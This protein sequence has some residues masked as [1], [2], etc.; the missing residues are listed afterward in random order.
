MSSTGHKTKT[1]ERDYRVKPDSGLAGAWKIAIG[2]GV[3]GLVAAGFGYT[4]DPTRFAF[5]YL[6]AFFLFL[7]IGLGGLFFVLI[8]YLTKAG[9]SVTVRRTAEFFMGGLWVFVILVIPIALMMG[10]LFPWLEDGQA[11]QQT[12][13]TAAEAKKQPS[14]E[15]TS[16]A[17]DDDIRKQPFAQHRDPVPTA[18]DQAREAAIDGKREEA[19]A[20]ILAGKK[21]YLN[22]T[23]FLVR[24]LGYVALWAFISRMLSGSVLSLLLLR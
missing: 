20:K 12:E 4:Q 1:L 23:F 13:Q 14:P 6:F 18:F 15:S 24:L 7:T 22:K 8:Q 5:S 9:W 17:D 21:P 19:E 11:A 3:I 10:R 16:K 2:V